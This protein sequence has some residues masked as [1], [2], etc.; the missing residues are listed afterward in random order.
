MCICIC[1]SDSYVDC[2]SD[3]GCEPGFKCLTFY[4]ITCNFILRQR[5]R[6]CFHSRACAYSMSTQIRTQIFT[7]FAEQRLE[8]DSAGKGQEFAAALFR[9]P[10][11]SVLVWTE[12]RSWLRQYRKKSESCEIRSLNGTGTSTHTPPWPAP[13]FLSSRWRHSEFSYLCRLLSFI[14][15]RRVLLNSFYRTHKTLSFGSNCSCCCCCCCHFT[16]YFLLA[17]LKWN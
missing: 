4:A 13:L 2:G 9:C 15:R 5:F 10:L 16:M 8:R 7:I 14:A 11:L 6:I 17:W 12:Y 3:C 1:S